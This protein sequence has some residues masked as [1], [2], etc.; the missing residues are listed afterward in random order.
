MPKHPKAAATQGLW[1][2]ALR[3]AFTKL[4]PWALIRNPVIAV[5]ALVALLTTALSLRDILAGADGGWVSLHVSAWLWLCVLFANF[6][7]ALAE[8][9]GRARADT[10]RATKAATTVRRLDRED[11]EPTARRSSG[12]ATTCTSWRAT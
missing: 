6:A 4:N 7:E 1:A 5:T 2:A 12:W 10:L 8:G 3:Q 9:R 11:Q